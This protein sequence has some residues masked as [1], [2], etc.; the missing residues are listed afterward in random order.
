MQIK[1]NLLIASEMQMRTIIILT[2]SHCAKNYWLVV[3]TVELN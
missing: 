2:L 3:K 1:P